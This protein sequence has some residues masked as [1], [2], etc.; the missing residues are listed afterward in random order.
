MHIKVSKET[1]KAE[2]HTFKF[3]FAFKLEKE[4]NQSDDNNT[5]DTNIVSNT[6]ASWLQFHA[7][8]I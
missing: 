8:L 4:T 6:L 2:P 1:T 3:S 5:S 7:N